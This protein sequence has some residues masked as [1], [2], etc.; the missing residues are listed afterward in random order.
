MKRMEKT[1][2]A[3]E[4]YLEALLMLEEKRSP[5]DISGVAATLSVS[6]PAATQMAAELKSLGYIDKKPYGDI[7]L[8]E[9]GRSL[10]EK[11]YHRHKVLRA[12]LES[13]GVSPA[14]AET[15]CCQIEHVISKETFEAIEKQIK[16]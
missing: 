8:T 5:L 10:G 14:T 6:M 9:S 11:T 7:F 3:I 15:D 4:D 16:K 2:K 1:S 13:L 12:Y